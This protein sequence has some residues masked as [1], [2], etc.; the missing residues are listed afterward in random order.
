MSEKMRKVFIMTATALI[1]IILGLACAVNTEAAE[2]YP[3]TKVTG[4]DGHF[5]EEWAGMS[6]VLLESDHFPGLYWTRRSSD[7]WL[8]LQKLAD[9]P[10]SAGQVFYFNRKVT[11][12]TPGEEYGSHYERTKWHRVCCAQDT[13]TWL[14][15][16][17]D[18]FYFGTYR[19]FLDRPEG[20]LDPPEQLWR[21]RLVKDN[22]TYQVIRLSSMTEV[23]AAAS[24]WGEARPRN[25]PW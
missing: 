1:I 5:V 18:G 16:R 23:G 12:R 22:G 20:I 13:Y 21:I 15:Q 3:Y 8:T 9:D 14:T 24:G 25:Y 11:V 6:F 17:S 10:V 2:K 4:T 7:G 19:D